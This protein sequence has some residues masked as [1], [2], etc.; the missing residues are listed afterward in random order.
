MKYVLILTEILKE[1]IWAVVYESNSLKY[2]NKEGLAVLPEKHTGLSSPG[3][4][5]TAR[6]GCARCQQACFLTQG[7]WAWIVYKALTHTRDCAGCSS[8]DV[9]LGKQRHPVSSPQKSSLEL[10][11]GNLCSLRE[12]ASS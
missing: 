1:N 10:T 6:L 2:V 5:L 4:L 3:H 7:R 9:S 11:L 12:S 8:E